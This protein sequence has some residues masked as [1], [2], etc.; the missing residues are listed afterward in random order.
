[1]S[2]FLTLSAIAALGS[3]GVSPTLFDKPVAA[4]VSSAVPNAQQ[5]GN[6]F[7][8]QVV[9]LQWLNPLQRRDYSAEWQLLWTL[10]QVQPNKDDDMVR[11]S[12]HDFST[13]KD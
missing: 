5:A 7:V 12:P 3:F 11:A 2:Q 1:M 13:L 9:G 6:K 4:Q 8:A 10:G